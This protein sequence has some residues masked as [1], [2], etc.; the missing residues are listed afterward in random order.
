MAELLGPDPGARRR[1]LVEHGRTEI[2]PRAPWVTTAGSGIC[3]FHPHRRRGRVPGR[4]WWLPSDQEGRVHRHGV[5]RPRRVPAQAGSD[6]VTAAGPASWSPSLGVGVV[7]LDA[8]DHG[9]RITDPEAHAAQLAARLSET[10]PPDEQPSSASRGRGRV[11]ARART[12]RRPMACPLLDDPPRRKVKAPPDRSGGGA[13]RWAPPT[14][15]PLIGT[16]R[17]RS[18]H[19]RARSQRPPPRRRVLVAPGGSGRD[20]PGAV[21]DASRA[22]SSSTARSAGVV[23]RLVPEQDA[24]PEP[25]RSCRGAPLS[26]VW[27][28]RTSSAGTC[29]EA[30][31]RPSV[32]SPPRA[33]C[34]PRC[35]GGRAPADAVTSAS[36]TWSS[37]YPRRRGTPLLGPLAT[38]QWISTRSPRRR[39]GPRR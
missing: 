22:T 1:R 7:A 2:S 13:C 19:R 3:R 18:P 37:Q 16:R 32:G 28:A 38:S 36:C 31:R 5:H 15:Y 29:S 9:D 20:R 34:A 10:T 6:N 33:R 25:R 8:P 23:G 12:P 14:A 11:A 39:P 35:S 26:S 30:R 21:P 4:A 17:P 24:A 27:R